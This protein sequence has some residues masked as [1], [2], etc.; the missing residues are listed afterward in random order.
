MNKQLKELAELALAEL[1]EQSAQQEWSIVIDSF[2]NVTDE[3]LMEEVRR[4][5]FVIRDA[6][7]GHKWVGLTDEE[8]EEIYMHEGREDVVLLTQAKLKDKNNG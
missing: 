5:G 8:V 7:V 3:A 2:Q 4:R 1:A 6:Q